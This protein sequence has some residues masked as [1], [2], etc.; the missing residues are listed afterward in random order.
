L[1]SFSDYSYLVTLASDHTSE[2]HVLKSFSANN[3]NNNNNN[4]QHDKNN[5]NNNNNN[6]SNNYSNNSHNNNHQHNNNTQH[7]NNNNSNNN[8]NNNNNMSK[9][10]NLNRRR[11]TVYDNSGQPS[12]P[13]TASMM[14]RYAKFTTEALYINMYTRYY[15]ELKIFP[16]KA[17]LYGKLAMGIMSQNMSKRDAVEEIRYQVLLVL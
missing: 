3:N 10:K 13:R 7:N 16:K 9:L 12:P 8:N 15:R 5:N 17:E 4:N 14:R 1:L 2:K 6:N 11:V